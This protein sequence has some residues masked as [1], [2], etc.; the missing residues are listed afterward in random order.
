LVDGSQTLLEEYQDW[1]DRLPAAF[2]GTALHDRLV[3]S[4]ERLVIASEALE[5]MD[6]PLGFGR[7]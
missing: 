2:E 7:D 5:D 3:D 4:V 1:L 6:P